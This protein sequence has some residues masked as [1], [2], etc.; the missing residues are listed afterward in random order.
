MRK[1]VSALAK[2]LL[3][4]PDRT[5]AVLHPPDSGCPAD[6]T[7][8]GG[9][10]PYDVVLVF[11]ADGS[12]LEECGGAGIAAVRE[13]G[14]LWIAYPKKSSSLATDLSRDVV[15]ERMASTGWRA[16]TQV[17]IDDDWSALRFRPEDEVGK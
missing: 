8:T 4:K 1:V 5:V 16:V 15:A 2:K 6:I 14:V 7:P 13:G 9:D 3:I 11:A 12:V 10:P 17:A